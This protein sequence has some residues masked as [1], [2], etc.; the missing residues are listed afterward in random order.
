MP[1]CT[2]CPPVIATVELNSSLYVTWVPVAAAKRTP[3]LPECA[4]VPSPRFWK[5]CR[6]S[7]KGARPTHCAPSPP[8]CV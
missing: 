1:P 4:K 2:G 5:K 7:V 6:V 8:I 3:R